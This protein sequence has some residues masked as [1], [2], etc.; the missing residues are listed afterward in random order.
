MFNIH[1]ICWF[2]IQD[3]ADVVIV[4]G[5][6]KT[7]WQLVKT[8]EESEQDVEVAKEAGE[9]TVARQ[10]WTNKFEFILSCFSYAVGLGTIWRFPYLCYRNGGGAF[11]VPYL[12]MYVVAG[13]PLFFF[14]LAF[15]QY[16]SQGP[17]SIWMVCPMFQG[18]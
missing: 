11:L 13:L 5:A 8:N 17:V 16:A 18:L 15:G 6:S 3:K 7:Q 2:S 10:T 14:E 12:I 4:D 1:E 9:N